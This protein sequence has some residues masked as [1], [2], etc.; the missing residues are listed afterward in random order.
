MKRL[1]FIISALIVLMFSPHAFGQNGQDDYNFQKALELLRNEGSKDEALD[2][3]D[4]QLD[5]TPNHAAS[6]YLRAMLYEEREDYGNA[7]SDINRALKVNNPKKTGIYMSTLYKKKAS[8]Y[9]GL[10]D[11]ASAVLWYKKAFDTVKKENPESLQDYAF[12]YARA[13]HNVGNY[14]LSDNVYRQMIAADETDTGAMVGM[15]RNC[16]SRGD[17]DGAIKI[18]LNAARISPDYCEIYRFL[19]K[20]YD[21]KGDKAKAIDAA[22]EY[23][24][25]ADKPY[26]R[27]VTDVCLKSENYAVANIRAQ[28]KKSEKPL[29]WHSFLA[30]FFEK[31][32]KYAEAVK[33]YDYLEKEH[34]KDAYFHLQKATCYQRLGRYEE[35]IAEATAAVEM[36]PGVQ[37]YVERGVCYRESGQFDKAIEDFTSGIEDDGRFAYPYYARGWTKR[38]NGDIIGALDDYNLGIDIDTTYTYIYLERGTTLKLLGREEEARKDFEHVIAVDTVANDG[39]CTY[40]ALFELGREKEAADWMQKVVDSNPKD[41]GN[42][43]DQACLF[44][45]MGRLDDA[46]KALERAFQLGY[47]NFPHLEFDMDMDPLRELPRYKDLVAKYKE[48]LRKESGREDLPA[49]SSGTSVT[50]VKLI[51]KIGGTFEVPCEIN[52]LPLKMIFDTGASDVSISSVEAN[53]MLK[54]DYLSV[55]DIKGKRYYQTASGQISPGAVIILN[56]VRLGDAVL[57]NVEASVVNSQNAP[58]LFGQSAMARFGTITIDYENN[59]LIIKH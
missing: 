18:L 20:A 22:I 8:I 57:K 42:V 51:R 49:A 29:Y 47:R 30:D 27:I 1:L 24:E 3:L 50:E 9:E 26:W 43:Y 56:E 7:L 5:K 14:E 19:L 21:M 41:F 38:L 35:S 48:V 6:L 39:S 46:L 37:S 28:L 10:D 16:T 53:F 59:K 2:L 32:F 31:T 13:L 17:A 55:N 58:L 52:G 4:K 45:R 23:F 25:K 54:N 33:E 12:N 11:D 44:S 36:K 40:Y 15:A 34:G